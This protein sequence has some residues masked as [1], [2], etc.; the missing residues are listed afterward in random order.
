MT[1]SHVQL[2]LDGQPM[3]VEAGVSVAA[4]LRRAS[5][6]ST[7]L[8]VTGQA[9]AAWACARNAASMSTAG[10]CWPARPSAARACASPPACMRH[11]S[12]CLLTHDPTP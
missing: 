4:A 3:R 8:S 12:Q 11:A 1:V 7:R 5:D 6:G 9:R 10:G 2:M